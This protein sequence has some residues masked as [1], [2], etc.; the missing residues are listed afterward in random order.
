MTKIKGFI[1]VPT[2]ANPVLIN[3]AAIVRVYSHGAS[4]TDIFLNAGGEPTMVVVALP[5]NSVIE[6]IREAQE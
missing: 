4:L 3:I 1:Q 2:A 5:Y 6:L